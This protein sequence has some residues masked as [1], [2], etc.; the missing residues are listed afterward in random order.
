MVEVVV[1]F[2]GGAGAVWPFNHR[3][4]AE[5]NLGPA[6]CPSGVIPAQSFGKGCPL[7][8]GVRCISNSKL[9]NAEGSC[10]HQ[11]WASQRSNVCLWTRWTRCVQTSG[12][13][14]LLRSTS[15]V[16]QDAHRSAVL[17]PLKRNRAPRTEPGAT[18]QP[19]HRADTPRHDQARGTHSTRE[20]R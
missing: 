12:F 19:E 2:F 17:T 3:G 14:L 16:L 13:G 8:V 4:V 11:G 6:R 20:H 10:W 5:E 15:P 1:S 7:P 18:A 9:M